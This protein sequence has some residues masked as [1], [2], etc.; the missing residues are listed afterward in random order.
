MAEPQLTV[1]IL[2]MLVSVILYF[3]CSIII[4]TS[5]ELGE[6]KRKTLGTLLLVT[7]ALNFILFN[8]L[9]F[10][11]YTYS[12][13]EFISLILFFLIPFAEGM[14]FIATKDF[15]QKLKKPLGILLLVLSLCI[16]IAILSNILLI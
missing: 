16:V 8:I 5:K 15:N 7:S 6:K 14:T 3:A 2:V 13:F 10:N 12:M 9:A 4:L 1:L 11:K